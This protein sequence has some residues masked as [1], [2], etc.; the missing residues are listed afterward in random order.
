VIGTL[1]MYSREPRSPSQRDQHIVE[2]ITHLAG[3]AIQRKLDEDKLRDSEEQWRAV[4]ENPPTMYFV[5]DAKGTIVSVNP[6]GAQQ[7]G[8]TVD[9]LVG[10]SVLAVFSEADRATVRKHV[11]ACFDRLGESSSWEL[12]RV[13]QDGTMIDVR[14]TARAMCRTGREPVI[15]IVSEDITERKRAE[16]ALDRA[17]AE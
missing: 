4:F 8:Y 3:I 14:E 7:L 2:Q 15:L 13:R 12:R 5:M 6:S 11:A 10:R 9:D 16:D 1:A 17:Q